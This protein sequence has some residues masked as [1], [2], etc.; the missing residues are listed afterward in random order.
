[1]V[2]QESDVVALVKAE[3]LEME[4]CDRIKYMLKMKRTEMLLYVI[5]ELWEFS[6]IMPKLVKGT[7]I[8]LKVS[9]T[10]M[11]FTREEECLGAGEGEI[12]VLDILNWKC[13]WVIH[14]KM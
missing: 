3:W 6:R 2:V 4:K 9:L 12:S 14:L 5:W 11:G 1:M 10:Q 7:T 8:Q 13:K